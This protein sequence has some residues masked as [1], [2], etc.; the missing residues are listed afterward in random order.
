MGH[1]G[2]PAPS[3]QLWAVAGESTNRTEPTQASTSTL[4]SAPGVTRSVNY[5]VIYFKKSLL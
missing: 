1:Q 2:D 3:L 4:A 5:S